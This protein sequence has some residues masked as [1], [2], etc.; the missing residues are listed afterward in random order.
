M[1]WVRR[2]V[3]V[4]DAVALEGQ[5]S[6]VGARGA[7]VHGPRRRAEDL[8]VFAADFDVA[9]VYLV[10]SCPRAPPA[11]LSLCVCVVCVSFALG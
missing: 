9:E 11:L 10:V 3:G 2:E 5:L 8:R 1:L 6:A 7:E 4:F